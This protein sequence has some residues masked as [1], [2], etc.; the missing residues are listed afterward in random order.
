MIGNVY[1]FTNCDSVKLYKNDELVAEF[2]PDR[3]KYPH[4][5]HPP[6]L[7]NDL[8]G[9]KMV[10][11]EGFDRKTEHDVRRAISDLSEASVQPDVKEVFL[12]LFTSKNA[13]ISEEEVVRLYREYAVARSVKTEFK[14][15]G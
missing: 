2:F 6:I 7:I 12:S 14:F 15:E 11:K 4:M 9:S 8:I 3:S 10:S 5:P 13:K 1:A